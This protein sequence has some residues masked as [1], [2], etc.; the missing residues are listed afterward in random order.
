[1]SSKGT[2]LILFFRSVE[3]YASIWRTRQLNPNLRPTEQGARSAKPEIVDSLTS[4]YHLAH[5]FPAYTNL[6]TWT[7][8]QKYLPPQTPLRISL[9]H[10]TPSTHTLSP[11]TSYLALKKL[12]YKLLLLSFW[13]QST[14]IIWL[15][16]SALK[17]STVFIRLHRNLKKTK[18]LRDVKKKQSLAG[19]GLI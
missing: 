1:M 18:A 13:K 19:F 5:A 15:I 2:D 12:F 16:K 3:G 7:Q 9:T 17:C 14:N 10:L 4:C 8:I 6:S 11:P